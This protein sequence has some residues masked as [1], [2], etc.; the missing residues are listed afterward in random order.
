MKQID[1]A[2]LCRALTHLSG[3]P[4]RI[5]EG[6]TL[7]ESVFPIPLP[8]DPMAVCRA[9]VLAVR[10]HVGY[11]MTPRFYCYGVINAGE[12]KIVVGPTAQ[13]TPGDRTLRELAFQADVPEAEAAAFVDGMK[14]ITR[15]P[16]EALLSLLC[17]VN[18]LLSG[19]KLELENV[20]IH[21]AEQEAIKSRVE[22]KRTAK[23]YETERPQTM[24]NTLQL[25]ETLMDLVRRGDSAALRKWLSAAPPV[26][27]GVLAA[28]QL[29]QLRN[30]F[31][32]SATLTSR[33][34]IRGGL[35]AEDALSLSDAFIQRAEQLTEQSAI[36][37]LQYNMI[38]E[39]TEQ[40]E[41]VRRGANPTKL[42]VDVANYVQRHLSEPLSTEAM[43]REFYLSR[44]HFSAK[45]KKETGMT[46]T[47]FIL[48]EK[49]EEAK[50]LLRYS[51]KSAAAIGAYLGFCSHG[52]FAKVFKK[53][54]GM[55]PGEY[56]EK[57]Q[58][59]FTEQS[60]S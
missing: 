31:I 52:H 24:H 44:T 14:Q 38:L 22:R 5:F 27:A 3:V 26:R 30:T 35:N 25:E 42:A 45:F 51:D 10:E 2:Y 16:L 13:I 17:T 57:H 54:A 39:F 18:Y 56:R 43:A 28:D 1:H 48:N 41:K 36:L 47:D 58:A 7:L 8:R 49:T 46:L 6:E 55:T 32:V 11:Y 40:V 15:A 60:S 19:E 4:T 9:E 34:A 20:A 59:S 50:R 21:G 37:N 29:R 23:V 12:W 53:Y 33:A